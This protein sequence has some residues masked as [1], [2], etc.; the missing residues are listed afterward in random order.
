MS[1]TGPGGDPRP[2]R[3]WLVAGGVHLLNGTAAAAP[4]DPV[5]LVPLPAGG[6]FH[7]NTALVRW[8]DLGPLRLTAATLD[9]G[10]RHTALADGAGLFPGML[11]GA[12]LRSAVRRVTGEEWHGPLVPLLHVTEHDG[13]L[14]A[15]GQ[16]RFL[17]EDACFV[18]VTDEALPLGPAGVEGLQWLPEALRRHA[19]RHLFL[20]NHQCY[21]RKCFP[22]SELEYKYTLHPPVD[23]WTLTVE[24][25]HR[26]RAGDLPGYVMEYRDEFQAWDYLNHLFEVTGPAG[27]EGYVSFIPTTDGKHL[28]KRKWYTEDAFARRESHTYGVDVHDDG[29]FEHHLR[30]RLNVTATRLPSFRRTRYDVNIESLRSGHVYGIFFD[31]C[32]LTDDPDT[33]LNQCELEYL[34]SRTA[35]GADEDAVLTEMTDVAAWLETFLREHGLNDD[36][37]HY[38]KRA[39][40]KD[41]VAA[42]GTGS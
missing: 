4:E 15:R 31:H 42:R 1:G 29:G 39:F 6:A 25:Y 35:V 19:E 3:S 27:E 12:A 5:V 9:G 40:L 38:S 37:G 30:Q 22:G 20:N 21:Y 14:H 11:P 8:Q 23:A 17:D 18:R 36:R 28:V 16:I 32:T 13:R 7:D 2:H 41:A 24:L 34:R 33:V 26:L 10:R